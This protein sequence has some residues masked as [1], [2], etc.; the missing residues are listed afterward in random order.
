[1]QLKQYAIEAENLRAASEYARGISDNLKSI[2][3]GIDAINGR[4]RKVDE[5]DGWFRALAAK[6][7]YSV[8]EQIN[9]EP[10]NVR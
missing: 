1:M 8:K 10:S 7:G 2:S 6:L 4:D 9:A 5:V 3:A